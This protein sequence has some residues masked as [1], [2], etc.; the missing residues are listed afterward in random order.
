VNLK[1][2]NTG[3]RLAIE[4]KRAYL[5]VVVTS[6]CPECGELVEKDL[7]DD[8]L[9]YPVA[10]G[11]EELHF[12]HEIADGEDEHEWSETIVVRLTIEAAQS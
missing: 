11:K 9:S 8:Y 6:E 1:I 12:C 4:L 2:V 7:S 3:E 5:P 10:N